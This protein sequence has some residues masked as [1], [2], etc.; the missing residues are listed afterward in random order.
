MPFSLALLVF[1]V[2]LD[3]LALVV[4]DLV[5]EVARESEEGE[6]LGS[7]GFGEGEGG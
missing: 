6:A 7:L 1:L 4:D 2:F 5:A 3:L